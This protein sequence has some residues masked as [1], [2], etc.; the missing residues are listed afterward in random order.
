MLSCHGKQVLAAYS[1]VAVR[2]MREKIIVVETRNETQQPEPSATRACASDSCAVYCLHP[3]SLTR[4][5][6]LVVS[7]APC[8][9]NEFIGDLQLSKS[10]KLATRTK[11]VW[12]IY[13]ISIAFLEVVFN[14]SVGSVNSGT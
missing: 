3:P 13:S 5:P 2:D 7:E 10:T 1:L 8:R 9:K 6:P 11:M 14:E 4:A 12:T